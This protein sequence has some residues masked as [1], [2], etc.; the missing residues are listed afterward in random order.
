MVPVSTWMSRLHGRTAVSDGGVHASFPP[1][2]IVPLSQ[3]ALRKRASLV[4]IEA[5]IAGLS[6]LG[7]FEVP[8][9]AGSYSVHVN[10]LVPGV[11][12]AEITPIV[13]EPVLQPV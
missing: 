1:V 10:A 12:P 9:I 2:H 3:T 7:G 6:A 5:I 11:P 4:S 8:A 13:G